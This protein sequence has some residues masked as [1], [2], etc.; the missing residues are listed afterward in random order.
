QLLRRRWL[1]TFHQ[2][3]ECNSRRVSVCDTNTGPEVVVV[4]PALSNA[5][6]HRA[7]PS[8]SGHRP[9]AHLATR[10]TRGSE[11]LSSACTDARN[12]PPSTER[13]A[14]S[15]IPHLECFPAAPESPAACYCLDNEIP[16][17][18]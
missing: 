5:M 18:C 15:Y 17:C 8:C 13:L 11:D 1:P 10:A 12:N 6:S 14:H 2:G 3:P 16:I 4:A 7:R 9:G